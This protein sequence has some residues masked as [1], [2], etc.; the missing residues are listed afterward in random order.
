[1][2][3]HDDIFM[4]MELGPKVCAHANLLCLIYIIYSKKMSE[5]LIFLISVCPT[6]MILGMWVGL[7]AKGAHAEF[8]AWT[9]LFPWD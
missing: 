9:M 8:W 6:L 2:P 3:Y 4:W 5:V 1:M 7:G